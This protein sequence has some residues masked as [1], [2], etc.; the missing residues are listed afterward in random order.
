[1]GCSTGDSE[2]IGGEKPAHRVTITKGFWLGQTEVTQAAWQRVVGTDPSHFKG[3]NLPVETVTWDEAQAYCRA[4]GGR[5]PT[6]A[7]W[8][9]AARAGSSQSRY[10]DI[11]A[12][13]WYNS[14]SGYHTHEVAQM[15]GN[16]FGLYDM[17]GN[18][19]EW[20]A[21]WYVTYAP[22]SIVALPASGQNRALRGGSWN[23]DPWNAR[24][25]VRFWFEPGYRNYNVGLRCAEE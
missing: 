7:E 4:V 9:Y 6:E 19:W 5:L 24:A 10:G 17:L 21:D 22:G 13:A 8:E 3:S 12:I 11:D 16:A 2:C 18:V 23:D 25:S 1:M 15:Q 20:T 14:N